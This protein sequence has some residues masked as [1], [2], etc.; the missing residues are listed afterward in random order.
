MTIEQVIE[1]VLVNKERKSKINRDT[2]ATL[3]GVNTDQLATI[4]R[5]RHESITCTVDDWQPMATYVL[6][7]IA[8]GIRK[9]ENVQK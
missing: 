8:L 6:E 1:K 5:R 9:F 4:L 2:A 3:L 7:L